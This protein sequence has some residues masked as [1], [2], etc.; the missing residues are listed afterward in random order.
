[1]L[2]GGPDDSASRSVPLKHTRGAAHTQ[3]CSLSAPWEATC[4]RKANHFL[5]NKQ[6]WW[7]IIIITVI[8]LNPPKI[9]V[10]CYQGFVKM[11]IIWRTT[12]LPPMRKQCRLPGCRWR[13]AEFNKGINSSGSPREPEQHANQ[14]RDAEWEVLPKGWLGSMWVTHLAEEARQRQTPWGEHPPRGQDHTEKCGPAQENRVKPRTQG[15]GGQGSGSPYKCG[16]AS[17]TKKPNTQSIR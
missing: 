11:A 3:D 15:R 13:E 14:E 1:M 17:R 6:S 7:F 2:T 16:A 10:N 5:Q 4:D 12:V 8:I 9:S